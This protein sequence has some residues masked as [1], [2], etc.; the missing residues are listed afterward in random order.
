MKAITPR[1]IAP[2]EAAIVRD[3]LIKAPIALVPQAMIDEDKTLEVVGLCECGCGS[4]Y[5]RPIQKEQYRVADGVG[6]L[7]DGEKINIMVWAADGHIT[8]LDLVDHLSKGKVPVTVCSWEEAG[9]LE[10]RK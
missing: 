3:A 4:L 7:D 5:F 2:V 10:A 6:Y 8:S 1:S 9:R